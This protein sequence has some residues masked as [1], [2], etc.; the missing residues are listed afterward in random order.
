VCVCVAQD[1]IDPSHLTTSIQA[2]RLMAAVAAGSEL[3][4][5]P[6]FLQVHFLQAVVSV[7]VDTYISLV[8]QVAIHVTTTTTSNARDFVTFVSNSL[9][10]C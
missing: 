7:T 4:N 1:I 3:E 10:G 2:A 5:N 9:S 6:L 8:A